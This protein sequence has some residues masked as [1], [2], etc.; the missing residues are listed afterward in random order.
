MKRKTIV[1]TVIALLLS[2]KIFAQ[3]DVSKAEALFVYNFTKGISWPETSLKGEFVI[4]V[5]GDRDLYNELDVLT[6]NKNVGAN[7]ISVKYFGKPNEITNSHILIVGDK[8]A[9][10]FDQIKS[11]VGTF[12]S[13]FIN[14]KDGMALKGSGINFR[15]FDDK[16]KFVMN[17]SNIKSKGLTVDSRLEKM[18]ILVN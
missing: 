9:A 2:V 18:A 5:V 10:S 11:S 12:P 1:I 15:L 6:K 7:K 17:T 14:T 4:G 3:V 16:M 13:L 8:F